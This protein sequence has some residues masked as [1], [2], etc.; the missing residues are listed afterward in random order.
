[1]RVKFLITASITRGNRTWRYCL[2]RNG[3]ASLHQEIAHACNQTGNDLRI[4]V[5][6]NASL[7]AE[8]F[9]VT[10]LT[11]EIETLIAK[12]EVP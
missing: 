6:P 11:A 1:M 7:G 2:N 12:D 9:N 5:P 10:Y 4:V 8:P 3:V